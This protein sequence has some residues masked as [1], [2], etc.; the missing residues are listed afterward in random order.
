MWQN[1]LEFAGTSVSLTAYWTSGYS[2]ASLDLGGVWETGDGREADCQANADAG[3]STQAFADGTPYQCSAHAQWNADL[4]AR[5]TFND[6]YTVY[7]DVL[8]VFDIKPE[9]EPAAAYSLFGY[10]PAWAG[11]NIVGRYYRVGVNLDF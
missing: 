10:N 5:H 4:T 2:T 7:L 11:P 9:F 8:N 6:K 3:A 1:T